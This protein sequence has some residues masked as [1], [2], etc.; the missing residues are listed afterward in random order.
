MCLQ[1]SMKYIKNA[2]S[3]GYVY[4]VVLDTENTYYT[5]LNE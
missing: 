2:K 3:T 1:Y 4:F 5:M